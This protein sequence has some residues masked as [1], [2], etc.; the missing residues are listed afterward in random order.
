MVVVS[1][2]I[3]LGQSEVIREV[4][5]LEVPP[6]LRGVDNG[7]LVRC[8]AVLQ[9]SLEDLLGRNPVVCTGTETLGLIESFCSSLRVQVERE[10]VLSFIGHAS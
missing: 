7:P 5:S 4:V 1:E 8:A 9:S 6:G 2:R 3:G 10:E